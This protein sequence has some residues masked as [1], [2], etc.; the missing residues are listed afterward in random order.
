ML[1]GI[2]VNVPG[3]G[4]RGDLYVKAPAAAAKDHPPSENLTLHLTL[5]RQQSLG[6]FATD[7][8]VNVEYRSKKASAERYND[9]SL[10]RSP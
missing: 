8:L 7:H 2:N 1:S 9:P 10:T 6:K 5:Q 3:V 4:F